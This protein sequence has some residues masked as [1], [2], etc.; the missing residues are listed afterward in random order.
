MANSATREACLGLVAAAKKEQTEQHPPRV[1][2]HSEART[3][4]KP[5]RARP[6]EDFPARSVGNLL[7]PLREFRTLTAHTSSIRKI[8][9]RRKVVMRKVLN[10]QRRDARSDPLLRCERRHGSNPGGPA[11]GSPRC[12]QSQKRG[13]SRDEHQQNKGNGGQ[14]K[15][16]PG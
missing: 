16:G 1:A 6:C 3:S 12:H 7:P 10:S 4:E 15:P 9:R 2:P 11:R 5:L 13:T 8:L 14:H